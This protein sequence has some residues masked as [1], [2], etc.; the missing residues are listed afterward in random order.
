MRNKF[1]KLYHLVKRII[2]AFSFPMTLYTWITKFRSET[3][4]YTWP[5]CSPFKRWTS[6]NSRKTDKRWLASTSVFLYFDFEEVPVLLIPGKLIAICRVLIASA[7]SPIFFCD[8]AFIKWYKGYSL[9]WKNNIQK[10]FL[11]VFTTSIHSLQSI[12]CYNN[13]IFEDSLPCDC[14]HEV[15]FCP[16]THVLIIYYIKSEFR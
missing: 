7:I 16:L 5:T 13:R 4:K 3:L 10:Y 12:K 2:L 14:M 15:Y 6:T 9:T 11:G 8:W 1:S